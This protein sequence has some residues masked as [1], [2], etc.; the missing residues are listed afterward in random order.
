MRWKR[1]GVPPQQNGAVIAVDTNP[2]PEYA[3]L[4]RYLDL[5]SFL[6]L[7]SQRSLYFSKLTEFED[8][9]EE[10]IPAALLEWHKKSFAPKGSLT[11]T[12]EIAEF[13]PNWH[14]LRVIVKCVRIA[15]SAV[16]APT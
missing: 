11:H 1:T 5:S 16:G 15:S 13:D 14:V 9:W 2:P 4:W 6:W 10:A 3:E 8:K 7:L 12:G